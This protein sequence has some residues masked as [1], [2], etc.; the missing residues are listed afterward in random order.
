MDRRNRSRMSY[1][2]PVLLK[3]SVDCLVTNPQGVYA[4]LTYGG[5]GHSQEILNR[6]GANGKLFGFDQDDDAIL[7]NPIVD[8]RFK[9]IQSNFRFFDRMLRLEGIDKVDGILADLGV[10]SHQFDKPERGFAYRFDANLDMR[11]NQS[12]NKTAADILNTYLQDDL[13]LLFGQY[14]EVRNAKTLAAK[15]VERRK[16][17]EFL[18]I[19]DF[20]KAIE[21]VIMG[22]RM[23]YLAQVFQA[24]RIEVN[25]EMQVLKEML[26]GC[27]KVLK[28]GGILVVISYHSLEDRLVKRYIKYGHFESGHQKDEFGNIF[29]PYKE[30]MKGVV[31]PTKEEL[32]ANSRA[33]SAKMR[34]A[35]RI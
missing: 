18:T 35:M 17:S 3:E 23:R 2:D 31:E 12:G 25:D 24:L 9:L 13:Q 19:Q 33:R 16:L 34:V 1:H 28:P 32:E 26:L 14:G 7:N 29:R 4:D 30:L 20:V 10:S 27:L 6:L 8:Q 22:D 21:S 5:G 11:M 15:I